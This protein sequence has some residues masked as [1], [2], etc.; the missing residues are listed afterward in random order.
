M[1]VL[2]VQTVI[3]GLCPP[4]CSRWQVL[5]RAYQSPSASA[6]NT[7]AKASFPFPWATSSLLMKTAKPYPAFELHLFSFEPSEYATI[8]SGGV[9]FQPQLEVFRRFVFT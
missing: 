1:P 3:S 5:R 2:S 8:S 7:S 4:A 6:S 9:S